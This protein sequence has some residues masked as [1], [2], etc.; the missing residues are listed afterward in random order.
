MR[1]QQPRD[2]EF[3]AR[4]LGA[5]AMVVS[6]TGPYS[7]AEALRR[8]EY[9]LTL[10]IFGDEHPYTLSSRSNLATVLYSEQRFEE[11]V[12]IINSLLK[13]E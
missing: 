3:F 6:N 10:D 7:D 1:A 8:E 12:K 13:N 9:A 5:H 11:A 4:A 2:N